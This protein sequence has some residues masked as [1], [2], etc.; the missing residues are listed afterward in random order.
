MN[1]EKIREDFPVLHKKMNGKPLIYLDS[2][3]MSL[4]P[5][6]VINAMNEYYLEYPA[7][8]GRSSHK[9]GRKATEK[10]D[11]ARKKVSDF[12]NAKWN[13]IVFTKNTT[14]SLNLVANSLNL[15]K[16]N[17]VVTTDKEHNSN[18]VPW[19]LLAKR[20]GIIHKIAMSN[21]D[22]TFDIERL[23]KMMDKN[24]RLVS[25][26][27]ASN[28]DGYTVPAREIIKIAHDNGALVILDCAQSVPH[29]K[30]DV[31]KLDADFL[32]FSGHK[33]LGPSIGVLYGKYHLLEKLEPFMVGGDTVEFTTYETHKL[34]KPPEKF[35]AGLQNYAGAIGMAAA[36]E[37]LNSAGLENI[38]KHEHLLNKIITEGIEN[39]HGTEIIGPSAELRGGI[40][41]FNIRGMNF[42]D[43]AVMLDEMANIAVRSG[44]HCVHSWFAAHGIEGTVRASL[45]LYN[46]KSECEIFT[47]NLDKIAKLGR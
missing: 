5:K 26:V 20:K 8:A 3:C 15:E 46:T 23:E 39:I 2:A 37:Y 17:V 1:I 43:V 29:S 31:R 36:V 35:E 38:G 41:S 34:L 21:K 16:G 7:C 32:A 14:E 12:I 28:L 25:M 4:K 22:G 13:E 19:Q 27:H 47:D 6:Q 44:Q 10:Y 33:M 24:V 18:L 30:I 45:Y 42:H 9:L 40:T 11:E